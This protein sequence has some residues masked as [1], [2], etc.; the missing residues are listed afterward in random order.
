MTDLIL[1]TAGAI[2]VAVI[3]YDFLRTTI[4]MSG[5]GL[6][7][8]GLAKSLQKLG[9]SVARWSERQFGTSIRGFIGPSILSVIA[10]NWIVLH[11]IGYVLMFRAGMSLVDSQSGDPATL[12]QTTAFIGSV[13]STLGA[14]TVQVT[15]GW[16][17]ILSMIAAV[18]GMIVLTLS[19]S[20]L[21]NILQTTAKARAFAVRYRALKSESSDTDRSETLKRVAAL[22]PDLCQVAVQF[23]ACPLTGVF[24]PDD[25]KMDFPAAVLD[26]CDF[27]EGKDA[28]FGGDRITGIDGVELRAAIAVLG[29]HISA[30][31]DA[32]AS[33]RAWA[34]THTLTT[35]V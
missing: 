2:V 22:G 23:T 32:F 1:F 30:G 4:S 9:F 35:K 27:L 25:T 5:L 12:V 28:V 17:D 15:D 13:L 14:S 26:L 16:W 24:V 34:R 31:E 10:L 33:V 8:R 29:R 20:F 19:V 6:F 11:A 3:F 18:N 7:S 21:F